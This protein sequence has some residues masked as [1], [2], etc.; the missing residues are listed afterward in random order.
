LESES[1]LLQKKKKKKKS[2]ELSD[3]SKQRKGAVMQKLR[4]NDV[5]PPEYK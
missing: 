5:L 3:D 1:V 2:S 4:G